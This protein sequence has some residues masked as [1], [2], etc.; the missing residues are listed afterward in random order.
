[1]W[2]VA[3]GVLA[4][5]LKLGGWTI[6]AGWSWWIV[7]SPFALAAIWWTIADVLGFTKAESVRRFEE[8][9]KRRRQQHLDAL[10]LSTNS[11]PG[12]KSRR[13]TRH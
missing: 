8:R 5:G 12:S 1:M 10:G 7:L 6:V 11:R 9:V 2:L 3:V 4:A 13:D